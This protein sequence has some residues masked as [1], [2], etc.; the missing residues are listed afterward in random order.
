MRYLVFT[1]AGDNT[2]FDTLWIADD[3]PYDIY[4]VYY[5][6]S[7]ER[8]N[9]YK[10]KV[11]YAERRKGSKFQN[12]YHV[13]THMAELVSEYDYVFILDDDILISP[14]DINAMF[15][16]AEQY[17]LLIC[18]PAFENRSIISHPITKRSRGILL[19]YTNFVEVNVPLYSRAAL[20]KLMSLYDTSL[21]GWGVDY[22]SVFA[23]G[24]AHTDRYAIVHSIGCSNPTLKD[25][26]LVDR[27]LELIPD[28]DK[29]KEL[30][31]DYA[32]KHGFYS[33][34]LTTYKTLTLT[35]D[36]EV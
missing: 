10:A 4:V 25:K 22:L 12:F 18:Q 6:D 32:S 27:E 19:A 11:K 17:D 3:Q 13:Y 5:G 21:I 36:Q 31:L 26:G 15:H 24:I 2:N 28:W 14:K 8:W 33:Y 20:A 23:N 30:W 34:P 35:D 16:I 7:D 1:S 29:R 9:R